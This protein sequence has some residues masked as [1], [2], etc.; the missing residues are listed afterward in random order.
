M[1]TGT[2]MIPMNVSVGSPKIR[3]NPPYVLRVSMVQARV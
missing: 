2:M 1:N 3:L